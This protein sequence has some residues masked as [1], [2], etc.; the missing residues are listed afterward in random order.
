MSVNKVILLG[1]VGH[2]PKITTLESDIKVASFSIATTERGY[3]SKTGIEIPDRTEWHNIVAWRGLA[4]IIEKYVG[5]GNKI[6]IEG[7]LKTRSYDAAGVTKY[8]TEIYADVIELLQAH[9]TTPPLTIEEAPVA[10]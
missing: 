7:K 8:I 5:K 1:N 9:E 6:Y 10:D 4:S 2:T 3:T